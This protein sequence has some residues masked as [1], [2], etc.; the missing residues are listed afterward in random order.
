MAAVPPPSGGGELRADLPPSAV[1]LGQEVLLPAG[2]GCFILG[3]AS[4]LLISPPSPA[5]AHL[6]PALLSSMAS[7]TLGRTAVGSL[8]SG[9]FQLWARLQ[10]PSMP[11]EKV[12]ASGL[13]SLTLRRVLS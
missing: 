7:W 3:P 4:F 6:T 1:C 9:V 10:V 12:K 8:G 11:A 5:S 2:T 13:T